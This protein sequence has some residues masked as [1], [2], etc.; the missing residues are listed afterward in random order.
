MAKKGRSFGMNIITFDPFIPDSV[1]KT[2]KVDRVEF[3]ELLSK[4][5]FSNG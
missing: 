1:L 5:I 3:D 2:E 4:T